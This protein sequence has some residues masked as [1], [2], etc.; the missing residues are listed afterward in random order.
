MKIITSVNL[1]RFK[2]RVRDSRKE[3]NVDTHNKF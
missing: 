2:Q 3:K 1:H